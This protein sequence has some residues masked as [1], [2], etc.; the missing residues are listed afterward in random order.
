MIFIKSIEPL[1]LLL[2]VSSIVTIGV[3]AFFDRFFLIYTLPVVITLIGMLYIKHI[4][5]INYWFLLSLV[6]MMVCDVLIYM[7][8]PNYFSTICILIALYFFLLTSVLQ[9][10]ISIKKLRFGSLFS[11]PIIL[12]TV[13]IIYLIFSISQLVLPSIIHAIP[14]VVVSIISILIF[15]LYCYF[16]HKT[17]AYKGSVK[18][19]IAAFIS[20]FITSLLPINELFYYNKVFTVLINITHIVGLYVFA[21]FLIEAKPQKIEFQDQKYL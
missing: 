11:F 14:Y 9:K 16:I 15:I 6:V 1:H 13:F 4:D 7:D 19:I 2:F 5:N 21:R 12:G 18:L 8:F 17:Y 3:A 20:I 10:F